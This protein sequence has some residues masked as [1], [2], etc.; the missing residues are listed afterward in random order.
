M[1][2]YNHAPKFPEAESPMVL[3]KEERKSIGIAENESANVKRILRATEEKK[4]A[5][6]CRVDSGSDSSVPKCDER[7]KRSRRRKLRDPSD[8][9]RVSH[10]CNHKRQQN[11]TSGSSQ[12]PKDPLKNGSANGG[13]PDSAGTLDTPK[14]NWQLHATEDQKC[15]DLLNAKR[16]L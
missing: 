13:L 15:Q 12:I 7:N 9:E 11:P 2:E 8:F 3:Y 1:S 10:A 6:M 16:K 4:A 14:I 5:D